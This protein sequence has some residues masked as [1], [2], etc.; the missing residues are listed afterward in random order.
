LNARLSKSDRL[1]KSKTL[2]FP[3]KILKI[4]TIFYFSKQNLFFQK[5]RCR[6]S[7][8]FVRPSPRPYLCTRNNMPISRVSGLKRLRQFWEILFRGG[9]LVPYRIR[10][11][12]FAGF[13]P[14]V[15]FLL[16]SAR[17][18]LFNRLWFSLAP[19]V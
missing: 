17:S 7:K 12:P 16:Q 3:N 6:P 10:A 14:P 13:V 8:I 2:P 11:D 1:G 15:S 4:L 5:T 18:F 19:F 9:C